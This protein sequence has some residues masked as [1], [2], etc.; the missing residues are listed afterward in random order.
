[1]KSIKRQVLDLSGASIAS[2]T[3]T[4][5]DGIIYASLVWTLV[6]WGNISVGMAAAG[7]ALV[8]GVVHYSLSRFWVFERFKAP[9]KQSALVYFAMSWLAAAAHGALTGSL[10]NSLGMSLGWVASKGVVW[11]FWIYPLSRYVVFGG[12]GARSSKPQVAEGESGPH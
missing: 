2:F 5:V 11:M 4:G 3:A 1:M 12:L 10:A 9:L 8:G 6:A 7:G